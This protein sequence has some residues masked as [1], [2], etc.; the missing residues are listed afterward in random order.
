M[1]MLRTVRLWAPRLVRTSIAAALG[2]LLV[3][4]AV[5]VSSADDDSKA[6]RDLATATDVRARVAAAETL[7]KS[8][9]PGARP[10]LEKALANPQP[11]VRSA[12]AAALA[13]LG[14]ARAVG[15]LKSASSSEST[16]GVKAQ[17]DQAIKR[18]SAPVT[19][20]KFLVALGR[21]DNKSGVTSPTVVSELKDATRSRIAQVP[22]VELLD[23][24]ADLGAEAKRRKLPV[25]KIDGSLTQLAKRT[26]SD[27]VG[28]A[29]RVEYL[30]RKMPE[31]TLKATM[32]GAAQALAD[33]K[34]VRG[35]R[36][37]LQ[38]QQDAVSGA[39]ESALKGV[40]PVLESAGK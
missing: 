26:G 3:V 31:Q 39:I 11:A 35:A 6:F 36:E 38:L 16:S 5:P 8:K 20:T 13:T 23:D 9:N 32:S 28:F 12:A 2:A 37:L 14:D 10:A 19:K 34:Q 25:F 21:I 27:G 24:G 29:A 40:S 15:A 18:L 22:G 17:M 1:V 4:G 7:G 30:V 33:E